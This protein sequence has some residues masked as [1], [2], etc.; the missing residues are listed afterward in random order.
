FKKGLELRYGIK[1]STDNLGPIEN[2]SESEDSNRKGRAKNIHSWR[3]HGNSNYSNVDH[4]FG[5]KDIQN[6]ISDDTFLV[7]DSNSDNYSIYFDIE[8]QIF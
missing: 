5:I 2:T 3:S 6:F 1:K 4:L 8:N 7:R